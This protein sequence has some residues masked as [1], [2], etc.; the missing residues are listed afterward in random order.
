MESCNPKTL[1][2][3]SCRG[4]GLAMEN[5]T[6]LRDILEEAGKAF[7]VLVALEMARLLAFPPAPRPAGGWCRRAAPG[8]LLV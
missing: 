8:G 4:I 2:P 5:A 6:Q 1:T 7:F 3:K